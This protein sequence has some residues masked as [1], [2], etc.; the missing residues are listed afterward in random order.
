MKFI[1]HELNAVVLSIVRD[2]EVCYI[3][4]DSEVLSDPK[5]LRSFLYPSSPDAVSPFDTNDDKFMGHSRRRSDQAVEYGETRMVCTVIN[6]F[7]WS[8]CAAGL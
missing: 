6:L 5:R 2:P 8:L 4:R 3:I 7:D 1:L